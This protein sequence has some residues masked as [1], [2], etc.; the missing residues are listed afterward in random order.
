[1][2]EDIRDHMDDSFNPTRF[3]PYVMM[4]EFEAMLFSN[5]AR[6]ANAIERPQIA[7]GLQAIRDQFNTP[8]EIDDSPITAPSKRIAD[9][10]TGYR[11]PRMG[12]QGAQA[13]GIDTIR[14]ECPN[15]DHWLSRLVRS[16]GKG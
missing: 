1:M 15:F 3:V 13:I 2:L 5:C 16:V 7:A 9:L 12:T 14:A 6:F 4:H 10:A 8:E 11:K